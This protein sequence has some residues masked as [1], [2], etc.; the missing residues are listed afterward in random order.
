MTWLIGRD[1]LADWS[2]SREQGQ[3]VDLDSLDPG[4]RYVC[5]VCM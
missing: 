4:V 5:G 3:Q 2:G 1:Q